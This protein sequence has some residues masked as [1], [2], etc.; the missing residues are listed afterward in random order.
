MPRR[1]KR[2]LKAIAQNSEK[3]K[4]FGPVITIAKSP[5]SVVPIQSLDLLI[6]CN[7]CVPFEDLS[8]VVGEDLDEEDNRDTGEDENIDEYAL[9]PEEY[10]TKF[11]NGA[12]DWGCV[13]LSFPR[14]GESK[15]SIQ[16]KR[17][18]EK[19][20]EGSMKRRAL[21]KYL[22]PLQRDKDIE[23]FILP[24]NHP[25]LDD[26]FESEENMREAIKQLQASYAKIHK[27]ADV[28]AKQVK[29][30]SR[31]EYL[32]AI[33]IIIWAYVKAKLRRLCIFSIHALRESLPVELDTI[34]IAFFRRAARHCF[35][36]MSGY[37]QGLVGSL[38]DYTQ[39]KYKG[40]RMIPAFVI[41]DLEKE[42]EENCKKKEKT[43]KFN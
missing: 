10:A 17:Q 27:N 39:R 23:D 12:I 26:H 42:Y 13:D 28:E 9:P 4:G 22:V 19:A 7:L 20:R 14:E 31:F 25:E 6:Y 24:Q 43:R 32:Q 38:L 21:I 2:S 8:D 35:R 11:W 3:G 18:A 41:A 30:S 5:T 1:S 40:H 37:R 29:E 36:F 34:P 16:R 15:R 33:C